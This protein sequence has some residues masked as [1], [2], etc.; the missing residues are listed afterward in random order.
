MSKRVFEV[1]LLEA[2]GAKEV[3]DIRVIGIALEHDPAMPLC[4]VVAPE[5]KLLIGLGQRIGFG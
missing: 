5:P 1:A 4:H 3:I 2:D